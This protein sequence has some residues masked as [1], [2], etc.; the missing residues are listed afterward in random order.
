MERLK[1]AGVHARGRVEYYLTTAEAWAAFETVV[2][3]ARSEVVAVFDG[4]DAAAPVQTTRALLAGATWGDLLAQALTRGVN[5][6]LTFER[7]SLS[8]ARIEALRKQI[9][10]AT[11]PGRRRGVLDLMAL[12]HPAQG[13]RELA[14]LAQVPVTHRLNFAVVDGKTMFLSRLG[15]SAAAVR[16]PR[17]DLAI[18]AR[19]PVV[20]EASAL[21]AS[22][23][24]VTAGTA[25]PGPARR[26]LR[27]F[28]RPGRGM[29]RIL[30]AQT[31]VNEVESAHHMLIRRASR[32]IYIETQ[33]FDSPALARHL[34]LRAKSAPDLQL[35]LILPA[36]PA[37]AKRTP[38]AQCLHVLR[39][40]F[41]RRI[42]IG[43][44]EG[45]VTN[46]SVFDNDMAIAGS[47]DLSRRALGYDTH[48]AIYLRTSDGVEALHR[49]LSRHWLGD[50]AGEGDDQAVQPEGVAYWHAVAAGNREA[51]RSGPGVLLPQL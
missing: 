35:V 37:G 42:F 1:K 7:T 12:A 15:L 16:D 23:V 17:R 21:M 9:E 46:V 38:E 30:G 50:P 32:T 31:I 29:R 4:F 6:S 3:D 33:E 36:H 44:A 24:D 41:G 47:A 43:R 20:A 49:R 18:I 5:L 39:E 11:K 26:L 27:T 45:G 13:H 19:G 40:A 25:E 28:S 14:S 34:A 48:A 10:A 51:G 22:F 8:E 2:L